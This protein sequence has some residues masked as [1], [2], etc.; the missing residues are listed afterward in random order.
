MQFI[1]AN[2]GYGANNKWSKTKIYKT[3]NAIE[4]L[5]VLNKANK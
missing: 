5:L 3:I 2:Y 1:R 4:E